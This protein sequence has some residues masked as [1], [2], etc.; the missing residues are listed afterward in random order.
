MAMAHSIQQVEYR[1]IPGF[2]GYRV[3]NDGSVWSNHS[4]E[5]R[6]LK[7]SVHGKGYVGRVLSVNGQQSTHKVHRLVLLAFIGPCPPNQECRHLDG[8]PRNNCLDNLAWGTKAENQQ[9]VVKHRQLRRPIPPRQ[10]RFGR[11]LTPEEYASIGVLAGAKLTADTVR[12][13][14]KSGGSISELAVSHGVT[15]QAIRDI[16]NRKTWAGV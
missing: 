7:G 9:D 12:E 5:W 2:P 8:N 11:L 6:K 15:E 1:A 13:I 16:L 3:G 10:W 14:R 4:G